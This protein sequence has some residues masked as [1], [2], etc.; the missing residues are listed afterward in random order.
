[1]FVKLIDIID[2]LNAQNDDIL[3]Y[4]DRKTGE[5]VMITREE[6]GAVED[7]ATAEE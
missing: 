1:M 3:H 2:A 5:I 4:L 6:L 7:R